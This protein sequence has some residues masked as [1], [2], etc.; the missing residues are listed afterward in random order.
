[1]LVDELL[2]HIGPVVQ[3]GEQRTFYNAV[4]GD[5]SFL[6]A[7]LLGVLLKKKVREWDSE[8]RW[9]DDSLITAVR[10]FGK[11][12]TLDGVMIWG[13]IGTT[14]EWV[15]RFSFEIEPL[16]DRLATQ[17]LRFSFCDENTSEVTY[18]EYKGGGVLQ[19][20]NENISWRYTIESQ[21]QLN[22]RS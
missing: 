5:S 15:D 4:L 16:F 7:G 3:D 20:S 11:K 6:L 18:E 19:D 13:K 22:A 14:E 2:V 10:L 12:L 8:T 21:H 9:M 17:R 1:M